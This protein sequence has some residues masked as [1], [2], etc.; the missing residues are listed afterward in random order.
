MD[1]ILGLD[2]ENQVEELEKVKKEEKDIPAI[3]KGLAEERFRAKQNKNFVESDKLR[4]GLKAL[5]LYC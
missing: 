4:D 1:K 2:L 5:G 3:I